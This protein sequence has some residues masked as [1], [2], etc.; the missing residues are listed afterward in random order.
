MLFLIIDFLQQLMN[1]KFIE[2]LER[3]LE[4]DL[5]GRQAHYKMSPVGRNL[6]IEIPEDRKLACV[7]ILLIPKDGDWHVTF[8][9]RVSDIPD[10]PHAGQLGFPGGK[11][12]DSDYSYQDCALREAEEEIGVNQS[13]IGII[14]ELS[15]LYVNVSNF[16]IYPFIGFMGDEPEF[17]L[18]RAEV[19]NVF[20]MPV[21]HF[22][23]SKNKKKTNLEVR[24]MTLKDVPYYEVNNKILWG[25]TAMMMSEFE[26]L[27]EKIV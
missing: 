13:E 16:L 17:S 4:E 18:Q 14:G 24:G 1:T 21:S 27:L 12:E 2:Q 11:F 15:S 6:D 22:I 26:H 23:G 9:E 3:Q 7:L 20:T 5:P 19:S 8:I 25:A 10:D